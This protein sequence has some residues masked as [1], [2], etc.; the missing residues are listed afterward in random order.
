MAYHKASE[1]IQSAWDALMSKWSAEAKSKYFNL[2]FLPMLSEADG[3]YQR[4][5]NLENY[6]ENCVN[7]LRT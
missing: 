7:S 6:V 5:E 2:I 3:M 1:E 4:N